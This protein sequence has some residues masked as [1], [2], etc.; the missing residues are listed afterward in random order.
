MSIPTVPTVSLIVPT[1]ASIDKEL[2][3][4][5]HQKKI[6]ET[7]VELLATA[8]LSVDVAPDGKLSREA[9]VDGIKANDAKVT[10]LRAIRSGVAKA[11]RLAAL[12]KAPSDQG[13]APSDQGDQDDGAAT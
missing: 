10:R 11:E 2:A 7:L 5:R 12:A 4:I 6:L 1:V 9:I 13:K 3:R 8:P